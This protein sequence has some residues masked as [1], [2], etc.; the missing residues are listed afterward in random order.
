MEFTAQEI[1]QLI[2]DYSFNTV[3][4][5]SFKLGCRLMRTSETMEVVDICVTYGTAVSHL[6]MLFDL[7]QR[8]QT[9]L[10]DYAKAWFTYV[11]TNDELT[12]P[13]WMKDLCLNYLREI[14]EH[15]EP[16]YAN[17]MIL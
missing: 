10:L 14:I 1:Q 5:L 12:D 8:L 15:F 4:D 11:Y 7:P 6:N 17:D 3:P 2:A 13:Q 16:S 9:D